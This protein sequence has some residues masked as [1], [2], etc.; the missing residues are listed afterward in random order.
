MLTENEIEFIRKQTLCRL[1][2]VDADG[3]PDVVPVGFEFD[4]ER[5]YFGGREME[6]TRKYKN[7]QVHAKMAVV[8]DD[9]INTDPWM[10]RGVKLYG[11]GRL[12][13][14]EGRRGLAQYIEFTPE[15]HWSWGIE[16]PTFVDG[17]SVF[18]RAAWATQK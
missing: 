15:R 6:T 18:N 14:R 10:P 4:G 11:T 13:E 3:Q 7:A 9:I 8:F 1:A 2:T 16:S 12:V 5:L 17:H